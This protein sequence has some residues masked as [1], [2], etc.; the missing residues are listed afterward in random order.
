MRKCGGMFG[1]FSSIVWWKLFVFKWLKVN[2]SGI[3]KS[4]CVCVGVNFNCFIQSF[5]YDYDPIYHLNGTKKPE[6]TI[7]VTV[8]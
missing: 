4:I 3:N 1:V 2:P 7:N 5:S 6:I 8:S